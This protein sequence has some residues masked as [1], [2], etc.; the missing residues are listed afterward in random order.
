MKAKCGSRGM[1]LLF[2]NLVV[3]WVWVVNDTPQS[4]YP[5]ERHP[6]PVV[7]EAVWA[8]GSVRT[9]A[10]KRKCLAP[11]GVRIPDCQ[12]EGSRCINVVNNNNNINN[13]MFTS[14][15]GTVYPLIMSCYSNGL[16]SFDANYIC[17]TFIV[18]E[19]LYLSFYK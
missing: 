6:A 1:A 8:L 16:S 17:K 9:G 11:K 14:V 12:S 18:L 13:N 2:F 3:R 7:Q 15:L 19:P 5:W 4:L 10:E